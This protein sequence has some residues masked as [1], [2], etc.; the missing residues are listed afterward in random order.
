[1]VDDLR[2]ALTNLLRKI[3]MARMGSVKALLKP[4]KSSFWETME[5][6]DK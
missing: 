4:R 3:E 1:M 2:M 6:N 5:P